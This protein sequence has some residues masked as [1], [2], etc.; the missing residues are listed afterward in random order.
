MYVLILFAVVMTGPPEESAIPITPS[1]VGYYQT[2]EACE[3]DTKRKG[4]RFIFDLQDMGVNI[5]MFASKCVEVKGLEG[6]PV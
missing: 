4:S 6:T 1:T 2:I 3:A 5:A